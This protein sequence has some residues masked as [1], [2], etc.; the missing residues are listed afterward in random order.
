MTPGEEAIDQATHPNEPAPVDATAP[1]PDSENGRLGL[2]RAVGLAAAP[3]LV[4]VAFVIVTARRTWSDASQLGEADDAALVTSSP[5]AASLSVPGRVVVVILDSLREQNG[6]DATLMPSLAT[7]NQEATSGPLRSCAANFTLPCLLTSFEG[8]ASPFVTA[9]SNF[10][11]SATGAPNWFLALHEA[12]RAVGI[13]GDHTLHE[14]YPGLAGLAINYEQVTIPVEQR[15]R[16][17]YD[18]VLAWLGSGQKLDV[19][20]AHVTGTDSVSH[21]H[22]PGSEP[23]VSVYRAADAFLSD[24]R[25]RLDFARDTL[26][27]FGDHGHGHE[28]HH[29][30]QAW[31]VAAGPGLMGGGEKALDQTSLLY[32]LARASGVAI[33]PSY[34][35]D[36][37]WPLFPPGPGEDAWRTVQAGR[38]GLQSATRDA[39]DAERAA[40]AA[41]RAYGPWRDFWAFLPWW[42]HLAGLLGT[43]LSAVRG[44]ATRRFLRRYQL[45]WTVAAVAWPT[46]PVAWL[47]LPVQALLARPRPPFE[48]GPLSLL[49][50]SGLAFVVG[51]VLPQ[52]VEFFHT[53]T[54]AASVVIFWFSLT[55][56]GFGAIGAVLRPRG[57][58]VRAAAITTALALT[59]YLTGPGVYYYG[60]AQGVS[61]V[62]FPALAL[63][64]ASVASV[65]RQPWAWLAFLTSFLF[66]SMSA[67]G[68]EFTY[69]L[70][71]WLREAVPGRWA[72]LI[73][74]SALAAQLALASRER[75]RVTAVLVALTAIGCVALLEWLALEGVRVAGIAV[76]GLALSGFL[77]LEATR[78]GGATSGPFLP[79]AALAVTLYVAFWSITD[80]FYLKNLDIDFGLTLLAGRF[81]READLALAVAGLVVLKYFLVF[82]PFATALVSRHGWARIVHVAGAAAVL[83]FV[84]VFCQAAQFSAVKFV[85]EEKS[86]ELI[87]QEAVGATWIVFCVI[88]VLFV[89]TAFRAGHQWLRGRDRVPD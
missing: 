51:L 70:H 82:L 85:E 6:R 65:R 57:V 73:V 22:R 29:D 14:L 76:L 4:L 87:L 60:T 8:R 33:H 30:R 58:S 42:L 86:S 18:T 48:P 19:V 21:T 67:G 63:L 46:L 7:L 45:L 13:I 54:N 34:E 50:L 62:A 32:V 47:A 3:L 27:V 61:H 83:F 43:A 71:D 41:V 39:L 74:A 25:A 17:T 12:G 79:G 36:Y 64:L 10:S 84:K 38:L 75:R 40:A 56:V 66:L 1:L 20:V 37:V 9:L 24:L 49:G 5:G 31:Y 80:G 44:A 26:V 16:F 23:Y 81:E 2:F 69:R 88:V 59:V 68:W 77:R 89:A 28:G 53:R 11:G 55:I 72:Y 52:L 35:G 78:P 15:D